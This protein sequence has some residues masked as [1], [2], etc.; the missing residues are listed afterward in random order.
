M[1]S[2]AGSPALAPTIKALDRL[3][4][5]EFEAAGF[6]YGVFG[7]IFTRPGAP[8][9]IHICPIVGQIRL[10]LQRGEQL[11]LPVNDRILDVPL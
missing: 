6:E 4:S 8:G 5:F 10:Q 3:A 1:D 9:G 2:G 7:V 11:L